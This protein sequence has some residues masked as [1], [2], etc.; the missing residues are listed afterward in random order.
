MTAL[1]RSLPAAITLVGPRHVRRH[2]AHSSSLK[3]PAGIY[4][5]VAGPVRVSK[6]AYYATAPHERARLGAGR[7]T[8]LTVSYATFAPKSTKLV[9]ASGTVSLVGAVSGTRVLML[10]GPSA[11]SAKVG[12]ILV[13]GSSAAA[14]DGYLVKVTK[15]TQEHGTA[16][17]EVENTTLLKALP[18]GE[19]DAEDTLEAPAEAA[20]LH[21]LTVLGLSPGGARQGSARAHAA[22]FSLH[23]TD[24]TCET[25]HGV[26]LTPSVTFSPSISIRAKWGF[27]SL[28]S[29]SF[30]A[31]VNAGLSLGAT[32]EAGA[33][34]ETKSP[35]IG[36]LPHPINLPDIDIQ[37][38]PFPVV[39]TPTLQLYLTGSA[40]ITAKV[41]ASVEQSA[42]ATVGASYNGSNH[43]ITPIHS[44]SQHFTPSFTAEGN[45]SAEVALSPTVDMLI[46]GIAGPSFD[47]GAAAKFDAST[48]QNPWWT[49]QGCLQGGVGF[50]FKILDINWSDA[51]LISACKTLLSATSPPPA[52]LAPTPPAPKP[53]PTVPSTGPTLVYDGDTEGN[54]L[55]GDTS[56]NDWATATGQPAEVQA[57]LP[58]EL[59]KYRCVG[60]L[61]N[62]A[63]EPAQT[64]AL[65][66]YL[67]AGGTIV[68][69]GEHTGFQGADETMNAFAASVGAGLVLNETEYVEPLV[70][71]RI[72]ASPF[73]EGVSEIGYNDASTLTV[74]GDA[75]PLIEIETSEGNF[76]PLVGEQSIAAGTFVMSGD[77][78]MF[79]DNSTFGPEGK[80]FYETY[81]NS[82]FV[83]NLCP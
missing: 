72:D 29:A 11:R 26:H 42:S 32:A 10:R 23:P 18:S 35:G 9:P 20:S 78:N 81:G 59:T 71:S 54:E 47:I 7:R 49:L 50:V 43:Q 17:L 55:A 82:R 15:V 4:T 73:T 67:R 1:P 79:S 13:S 44:F 51:N 38:G 61:L 62:R 36:L 76:A 77:S 31:S 28:D 69:M 46:Y 48:S 52:A 57:S 6:G 41:S 68:A 16:V 24:L 27:F 64:E 53:T 74:S 14:P 70:T 80:T 66:S 60:M 34:C 37:V 45:A 63:L 21:D 83:R 40:S 58:S 75:S 56:F 30:T 39:I 5:L 25:T 2:V 19:I 22:G 12:S 33:H 3:L 65:T 8:T